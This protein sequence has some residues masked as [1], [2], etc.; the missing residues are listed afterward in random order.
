MI[1][2]E[3]KFCFRPLILITIDPSRFISSNL[4]FI[5]FDL[6]NCKLIISFKYNSFFLNSFKMES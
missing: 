4:P 1:L 2:A 6:S 5:N 3:Y